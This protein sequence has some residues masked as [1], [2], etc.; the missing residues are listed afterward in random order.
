[1]GARRDAALFEAALR[2][3]SDATMACGSC[4][5]L[6]DLSIDHETPRRESM[7]FASKRD[8]GR[9]LWSRLKRE[10]YPSGY[11][12]LCRVCNSARNRI[13]GPKI[14]PYPTDK[15]GRP[16]LRVVRKSSVRGEPARPEWAYPGS[17]D[18][19][20]GLAKSDK[21]LWEKIQLENWWA[22]PFALGFKSIPVEVRNFKVRFELESGLRLPLKGRD[23]K[24]G[25]LDLISEFYDLKFHGYRPM[26]D[27][28]PSLIDLGLRPEYRGYCYQAPRPN[29]TGRPCQTCGVPMS[30]RNPVRLWSFPRCYRCGSLYVGREEAVMRLLRDRPE[31]GAKLR[32]FARGWISDR[33]LRARRPS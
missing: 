24:A 22:R 18:Y 17:R 16:L 32:E 1:M 19:R 2:K 6:D 29:P 25:F 12:V 3:Y 15:L 30:R 27:D 11:R 14:A 10:G 4:G 8:I 20:E 33:P 23:G 26:E 9:P 28:P 31:Y 13:V 7:D 21:R 5:R